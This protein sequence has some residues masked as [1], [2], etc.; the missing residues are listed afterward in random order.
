MIA[1][2][3]TCIVQYDQAGSTNY[4]PAVQASNSVTAT[5]ANQTIG[6]VSFTPAALAVAVREDELVARALADVVG[7]VWNL[8]FP[9]T[10]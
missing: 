1:A 4:F 3:G 9:A 2:N 10:Q 6:T 5:K 8:S 7:R